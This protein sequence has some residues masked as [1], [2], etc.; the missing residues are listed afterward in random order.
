MK[1]SPL[2]P[3]ILSDLRRIAAVSG[4]FNPFE[5]IDRVDPAEAERAT[6]LLAEEADEDLTLNGYRWVLKADVRRRTLQEFKE[7]AELLAALKQAPPVD[8][9]DTF[10]AALR[11]VLRQN[12]RR[13]ARGSAPRASKGGVGGED[14]TYAA[15]H[16]VRE[17]PLFADNRAGVAKAI[18]GQGL[19]IIRRQ[20]EGSLETVLSRDKPL[21]GRK[22][23]LAALRA[24]AGGHRSERP[25]LLTGIGGVGK[26]ALLV[27]IVRKTWRARKG[28]AI[29]LDFDR[30]TLAGA[31]PAEIMRDFSRQFEIDGFRLLAGEPGAADE[32]RKSLKEM[33]GRLRSQTESRSESEAGPGA[34]L[35]LSAVEPDRQLS[36]LG[37]GALPTFRDLPAVVREQPIL[38]VLDT[39]ETIATLGPEV[40]ARVLELEMLLR[41]KAGLAGLRT[42]ISGRSVDE[43]LRPLADRLAPEAE[44]V[45]LGGLS[46]DEGQLLLAGDER[47]RRM[48]TAAQ[49]RQAS[50][51]LSGHPL[52]LKVLALYCRDQSRKGI[53]QLLDGLERDPCLT[54]EFAQRFLYSRILDR[55]NDPM[56][57]RLAHPG[58]VLRNVS[59]D[60]IRLVLAEA[61]DLGPTDVARS[62]DL[63]RRLVSQ[64]WL[65]EPIG[66]SLARHRPDLR[67]QMVGAMFAPPRAEDTGEERRRKLDLSARAR[68][69]SLNA[70][71]FFSTEPPATDPVHA[72]WT[73]LGPMEREIETFYH[74]ALTEP[75][76]EKLDRSMARRLFDAL[77]EELDIL[78]IGWR[79]VIKASAGAEGAMNDAERHVLVGDLRT[80]VERR[81]RRRLEKAGATKA[82]KEAAA[83]ESI[84]LY[85]IATTT[86][87]GGI[88]VAALKEMSDDQ[89]DAL[90]SL[91][92]S[93]FQEGDIEKA[94]ELAEP[95]IRAFLSGAPYFAERP[96]IHFSLDAQFWRSGL[97]LGTLARGATQAANDHRN[98]V[99]RTDFNTRTFSQLAAITMLHCLI[100]G[101]SPAAWTDLS[102]PSGIGLLDRYKR[103]WSIVDSRSFAVLLS[104]VSAKDAASLEG[105]EIQTEHLA[106][107]N[108]GL[109]WSIEGHSG[110]RTLEWKPFFRLP[111]RSEAFLRLAASKQRISLRDVGSAISDTRSI[112]VLRTPKGH[113]GRLLF[114]LLRGMTPELHR[115]TARLIRDL[116]PRGDEILNIMREL[117]QAPYWPFDLLVDE[118]ALADVK[119]AFLISEPLTIVEMADRCGRLLDLLE[120]L[121]RHDPRARALIA[122]HRL[123]TRCL[124]PEAQ[125]GDNPRNDLSQPQ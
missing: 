59:P 70:V 78:P 62:E 37:S 12:L 5:L 112:S 34:R 71:R 96:T 67:R 86:E 84:R 75:P 91:V 115:P 10:G 74:R 81:R 72:W 93:T 46:D 68:A 45:R 108:E 18:V 49:R 48:L 32:A 3:P 94:G 82:V 120:Q 80:Q 114:E 39:F 101:N 30:P 43:S 118:P 69:A 116:R 7:R 42:V 44:W 66:P 123:I 9:D 64:H 125:D 103:A 117:S 52:A 110:I 61:C 92:A 63:F 36:E 25:T 107:L 50:K 17:M 85:D 24:F 57:R 53:L 38:L 73:A 8:A 14:A 23:Q 21:I 109:I 20:R 27:E 41:V 55:I 13:T 47:L 98:E 100:Q 35:T 119:Q 83:E 4:R 22:K 56:L 54:A 104:T 2:A 11:N 122:V 99:L 19:A 121:A 124:F 15:L 113:E 88:E 79:A 58:L 1:P 97:W 111:P 105:G 77:P 16:F 51:V 33:R 106:L 65:V 40:V 102:E 90:S 76:P 60:L 28:L 26:S 31:A 29:V 6:Q 87:D 89:L 95:L